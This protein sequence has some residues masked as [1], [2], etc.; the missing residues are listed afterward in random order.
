M[1]DRILHAMHTLRSGW[2]DMARLFKEGQCYTLA[3][4]IQI[5]V[6]N[7]EIMYSS[8]EG[9]VYL[10]HEDHIYDIEGQHLT[11][12]EDLEL[13][14]H[15]CGDRPHRWAARDTRYLSNHE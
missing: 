3:R 4:M 5:L 12:P 10:R 8:R 13:L 11:P 2:P 9:H 1:P 15:K 6:P 7:C 14:D